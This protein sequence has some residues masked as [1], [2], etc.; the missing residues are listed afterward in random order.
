MTASFSLHQMAGHGAGHRGGSAAV[1][2]TAFPRRRGV[3]V[4]DEPVAPNAENG[5]F[6]AEREVPNMASEC[7]RGSRHERGVNR[8][9]F[10]PT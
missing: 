9:P 4:L 2:A 3:G 7:A 6:I 5:S 10:E 1:Y 8:S